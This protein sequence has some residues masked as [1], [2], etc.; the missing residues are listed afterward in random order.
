MYS[1]NDEERWLKIKLNKMVMVSPVLVSLSVNSKIPYSHTESA[2]PHSTVDSLWMYESP[3][4]A[5]KA[6]DLSVR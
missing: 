5:G 2:A 3:R 6:C 4:V 1:F